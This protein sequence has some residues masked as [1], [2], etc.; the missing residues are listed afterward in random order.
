M[1][2]KTALLSNQC[3]LVVHILTKED[4]KDY[5]VGTGSLSK[6]PTHE[7]TQEKM[8][9]ESKEGEVHCFPPCY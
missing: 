5:K 4:E 6:R 8:Y 1:A 3:Y 7:N 9:L 2:R